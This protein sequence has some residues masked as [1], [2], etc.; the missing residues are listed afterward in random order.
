MSGTCSGD[1]AADDARSVPA[2]NS[3]D[4]D[5]AVT[6]D[7]GFFAAAGTNATYTVQDADIGHCIYALMW[8]DG[9]RQANSADGIFHHATPNPRNNT[10][11][12]ADGTFSGGMVLVLPNT[13]EGRPAILLS[14]GT[15]VLT[16]V[17]VGDVL[18]AAVTDNGGTVTDADGIPTD[19]SAITVSWQLIRDD[20]N[21]AQG[22]RLGGTRD[23]TYTVIADD[24]RANGRIRVCVFFTDN[25]GNAE[26]GDASGGAVRWTGGT[27]CSEYLPVMAAVDP[28]P[29]TGEP[30]VAYAG[31]ITAPTEDST[32]TASRGTIDD[33]N[34]IPTPFAP[35]LAVERGGK[36]WRHLHQ[37]NRHHRQ[38][39]RI[40]P[41][42]G[43]C[44]QVPASLRLF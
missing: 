22:E 29:A 18:Q 40:H 28:A 8:F 17:R 39:S 10:G 2:G 38:R 9:A 19:A 24:A 3:G 43:A 42:A 7:A 6:S 14:G 34:G 44:G 25:R 33:V 30:A 23:T 27:L 21:I 35:D 36:Q 5:A 15:E 31:S 1:P 41:P 12:T 20:V 16:S 13:A 26:G 32:I 4:Y 11:G 37:H